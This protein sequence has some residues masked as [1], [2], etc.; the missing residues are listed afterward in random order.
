M[1][2]RKVEARL[3]TWIER[4]RRPSDELHRRDYAEHDTVSYSETGCLHMRP[5]DGIGETAFT[6]VAN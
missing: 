3:T 6:L 4:N 5:D 1:I 2:R